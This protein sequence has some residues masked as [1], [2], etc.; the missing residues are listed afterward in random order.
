MGIEELDCHADVGTAFGFDLMDVE[1]LN[2]A[3]LIEN[4]LR[5]SALPSFDNALLLA[6]GASFRILMLFHVPFLSKY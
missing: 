5:V 3:P 6:L 1:D 4:M 2:N